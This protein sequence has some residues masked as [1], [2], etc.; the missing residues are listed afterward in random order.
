MKA[1]IVK[2][3]SAETVRYTTIF[4]GPIKIENPRVSLMGNIQPGSLLPVLEPQ[5]DIVS[6]FE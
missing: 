1:N 4:R 5:D 2:M 6:V 3:W